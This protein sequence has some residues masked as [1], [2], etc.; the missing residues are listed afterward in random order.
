LMKN[1]RNERKTM[2]GEYILAI[3]SDNV[4]N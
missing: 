2:F 4:R 3:A 1:N